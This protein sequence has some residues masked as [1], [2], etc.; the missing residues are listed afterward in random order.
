MG[1]LIGSSGGVGGTVTLA[2]KLAENVQAFP[3]TATASYDLA[4]NGS[5]LING[6]F[7]SVY[8]TPGVLAPLLEVRLTVLSGSISGGTGAW[9]A[10]GVTTWSISQNIIGNNNAS[11][12]VEVREAGTGTLRASA[13]IT[14]HA[15]MT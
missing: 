10:P 8:C 9:F 7:D 15:Q 6:G 14:F 12:F 13:T 4:T 2:D 11:G 5:V 1:A 3:T